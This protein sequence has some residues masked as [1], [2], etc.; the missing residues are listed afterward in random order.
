V[1][2]SETGILVH[3][4][5]Q[6]VYIRVNGRGSFQN[7]R[8]LRSFAADL[9]LRGSRQFVI[10][11]EQCLGMD[12][13]FLGVLTGIGLSLRQQNPPGTL[14]IIKAS[15]H[16]CNLLKSLWLDRLFRVQANAVDLPDIVPPA[17][18]AY[19]KLPDSDL[20]GGT[21]MLPREETREVMLTAH[22]DLIRADSRNAPKFAVVTK[23]L[24]EPTPPLRQ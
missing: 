8:P 11:L 19:V 5:E 10:D 18:A 14:H 16:N 15:P 2:N 12:S 21:K 24:R 4:A 17:A 7:S 20:S 1:T 9:I 22:D 3:N 6:T 13:T 23:L